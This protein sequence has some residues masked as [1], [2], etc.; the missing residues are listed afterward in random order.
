AQIFLTGPQVIKQVT[1]E[2]VTS[3][4]LGGLE[5]QMNSGVVHLIVENDQE[6]ISQCRRL[7]SFL[8]S[9]NLEDPPRQPYR[10]ALES[11]PELNHSV[12]VDSKIGYDVRPILTR[13]VDHQDFL[14]I[15]P[16]FA[17]NIVIGFARIQGRSVGLVANQPCVLSGALDINASDK[18]ARF[19]RFC[20][21]FNIPLVT[22]VDVPGFLPGVEQEHGGIVRHGAKML[23]ACSA[24]TVPKITVIIRKAYGGAYLAMCA[25]ELGADRVVAW[26]TAEIAVMGAEGAAETVFSREIRQ[27]SDKSAKRLELIE[28]YR[29]TFANPYV[30]AG[31]RMVDDVIE[32]SETRRYLALALESLHAKRESR[33]PKKHGLIPL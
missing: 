2:V 31:R 27:A 8:P 14:E 3:E 30:A 11:D 9:N 4:A 10:G 1:G 29:D 17:S 20:N 22:F 21:A 6:A 25:K 23:F 24:A 12:P 7:L 15:Q 19:I 18:A 32:P 26:P 33:P 13:I 5:A 16:H 28:R